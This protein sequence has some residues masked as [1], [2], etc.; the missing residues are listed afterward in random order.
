MENLIFHF[1]FPQETGNHTET[2]FLNIGNGRGEG[3]SVIGCDSF[4][5]S[6]HDFSLKNLCDAR[7]ANELLPAEESYLYLDYA[8]RA[9]GS[10]S[11]GPDPEA[12]YEL[13][14]HAF[15]FAFLLCPYLKKEQALAS[16]RQQKEKRTERLS[17]NYR[18]C[19]AKEE[20]EIAEC[21]E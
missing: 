17:E 10:R 11:C 18:F 2:A 19:E 1:D 12:D 4:D 6:Y 3:I 20:K 7:H 16:W 13:Y 14:P 5:F 9:L 8:M 21:K 15:R